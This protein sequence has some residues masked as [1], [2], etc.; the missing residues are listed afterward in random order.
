MKTLRCRDAGFDCD[1]QIHA[2]TEAEVLTQA[3]AHAANVHHV[4][5]TPEMAEEIK[6]LIRDED[7]VK[8]AV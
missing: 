7:H 4:T 1:A 2:S 5:I 8:S 3:A 6:T